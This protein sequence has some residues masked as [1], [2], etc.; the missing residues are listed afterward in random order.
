MN[1]TMQLTLKWGRGYVGQL[2]YRPWVARITGT[3]RRY[4]LS[5]EF[6]NAALV[7]AEHPGRERTIIE[8][9][10]DLGDGLY[11]YSEYGARTFIRVAGGKMSEV[12]ADE[13]LA[14]AKAMAQVAA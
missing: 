12:G 1:Q 5:R 13:A 8:Y 10:Y 9:T 11:E 4:G 3:D 6:L 2:R 14:E 7:R